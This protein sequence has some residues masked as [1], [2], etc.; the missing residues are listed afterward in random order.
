MSNDEMELTYQ[1]ALKQMNS[2][3]D[4][5]AYSLAA[6]RFASI[7]GYK[8]SQDLMNKCNENAK[9]CLN[10]KSYLNAV[11]ILHNKNAT[12]EDLQRAKDVLISLNGWGESQKQIQ[13]IDKRINRSAGAKSSNPL[14]KHRIPIIIGAS[15]LVVCLLIGGYYLFFKG[16]NGSSGKKASSDKA[17]SSMIEIPFDPKDVIDNND[18]KY[19]QVKDDLEA[20]GFTNIDTEEVDDLVTGWIKNKYTVES[21]S[22]EGN[23]KFRKGDEFKSDAHIIIRYHTT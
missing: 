19:Q 11:S 2:S 9:E 13:L 3:E 6:Q 17:D 16:K 18:V 1:Q 23:R 14:N 21:I 20:A 4:E 8:D 5:D 12:V 7:I 10:K 22:I 15:V